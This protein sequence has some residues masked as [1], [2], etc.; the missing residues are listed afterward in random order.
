MARYKLFLFDHHVLFLRCANDF[1]IR[2]NSSTLPYFCAIF[3]IDNGHIMEWVGFSNNPSKVDSVP[4]SKC[5]H[6][7]GW[8][9]HCVRNIEEGDVH[10]LPSWF[11]DEY[12]QEVVL[13]KLM[14]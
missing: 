3:A 14:E 8:V 4:L 2:D 9:L 1:D 7:D 10:K 12:E 13:E 6:G 11:F 5:S